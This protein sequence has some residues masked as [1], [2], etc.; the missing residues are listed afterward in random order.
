MVDNWFMED[1]LDEL[2]TPTH[3]YPINYS[4]LLMAIVLWDAV[5]YPKNQYNWW[6]TIPSQVQNSLLPLDDSREYYNAEALLNYRISSIYTSDDYQ[7]LDF[8]DIQPSDTGVVGSGALRYMMFS[9]KNHADYLPCRKRRLY[10]QHFKSKLFTTQGLLR[11]NRMQEFDKQINNHFIESFKDLLNIKDLNIEM[12]VLTSYIFDNTP[13]NMTPTDFA[14]HLRESGPAVKYRNYLLELEKTLANQDFKE[15]SYLINA[16][17]DATNDFLKE[18]RRALQS[19]QATLIPSL[20]FQICNST[21]INS[22]LSPSSLKIDALCPLNPRNLRFTF[23]RDL[24]KYALSE[25]KLW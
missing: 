1:V 20:L 4:E 11:L 24:S 6:K 13:I 21:H 17:K 25:R 3:K 22:T 10:L 2:N 8:N 16:S 18:H 15:L 7:W 12:P 9:A 14:F 5:Y 23:L 19:I